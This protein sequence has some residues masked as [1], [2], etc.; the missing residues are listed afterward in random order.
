MSR[1]GKDVIEIPAT[2][3]QSLVET[4]CYAA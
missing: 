1:P 2:L 3:L 4:V